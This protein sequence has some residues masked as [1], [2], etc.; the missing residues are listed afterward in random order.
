[1]RQQLQVDG[2]TG[3]SERF[4][5]TFVILFLGQAPAG[6]PVDLLNSAAAQLVLGLLVNPDPITTHVHTVDRTRWH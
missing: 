5:P 4:F 3:C 2:W 1:M 6:L